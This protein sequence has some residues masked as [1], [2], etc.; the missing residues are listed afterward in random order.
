MARTPSGR[1]TQK[2]RRF[3]EV[4]E[5]VRKKSLKK[6]K[7]FRVIRLKGAKLGSRQSLVALTK[8]RRKAMGII[9]EKALNIEKIADKDTRK[10]VHE[11]IQK[12]LLSEQVKGKPSLTHAEFTLEL[13]N[14]LGK[15]MIYFLDAFQRLYDIHIAKK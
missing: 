14:I 15:K 11:L 7:G 5:G 10:K 12:D 2:I 8:A 1:I 6:E 13:R 3:N 9:T 4:G